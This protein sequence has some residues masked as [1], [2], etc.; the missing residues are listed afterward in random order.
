MTRE[1]FLH[2]L[3]NALNGLNEEEI[4]SVLAYYNEMIDDRV[5][6]G[7][8]EEDAVNA[9]ES[10]QEIASR[11]LSEAGAGEEKAAEKTDSC[12]EIRKSAAD[13]T[14]LSITAENQRVHI[15]CGDT[16][17]VVLRYCIEEKD[18]YQLHEEN[19]LLS[20]E[21]TNRPVSSYK[22]D[23]S[24][25]TVDKLFD[26]VGKFIKG[27]N[28]GNMFTVG[29]LMGNRCIDVIL[30]RVFKGKI[31]VRTSNCRITAENITC[32]EQLKAHTSN[33]RIELSHVAAKSV[34]ATSSNARIVLEDVYVRE[35]LDAATSNSSIRTSGVTAESE[36]Q[37][38]TSN[39]RIEVER[40]SAKSITL[41]TCNSTIAGSVRGEAAEY[42]VNASTSNGRCTLINKAE[43]EK[44]LTVKT[45]NGNIN[46]EFE[47]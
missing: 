31:S 16:D 26:E 44:Q 40:L 38:K 10:V 17:E 36:V 34:K 11:V 33:A 37:L 15:S 2:D 23:P 45:S 19:G 21:H 5:E 29:T 6:A 4:D 43:G 27:L 13:V 25:V 18:V 35:V 3:K 30:P 1:I 41:R 24:K 12:K 8:T 9:M 46:M 20:L 32:M 14:E 42:A 22:F 28:L 7:M 47:S 39:A